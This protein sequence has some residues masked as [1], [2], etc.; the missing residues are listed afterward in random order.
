MREGSPPPVRRN[1][2]AV[3]LL[4]E[5]ISKLGYTH[6]QVAIG[7]DPAPRSCFQGGR[8]VLK[9]EEREVDPAVLVELWVSWLDGYP[10][11]SLE[12][13]MAKYDWD[14]WQ[15]LTRRLGDRV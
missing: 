5:A 1:E 11:I 12:D 13:G 4:V 3:E 15:L 9:G 7:L 6:D 14:G 10:I 2:E 8:Y